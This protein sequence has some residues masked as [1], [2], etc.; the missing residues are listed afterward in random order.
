MLV[1]WAK[2]L[3]RVGMLVTGLVAIS[4]AARAETESPVWFDSNELIESCREDY[5]QGGDQDG[6]RH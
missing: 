6:S 3:L 4:I 2:A 1:G 5:S